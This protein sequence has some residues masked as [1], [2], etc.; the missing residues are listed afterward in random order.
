MNAIMLGVMLLPLFVVVRWGVRYWR[1]QVLPG[2]VVLEELEPDRR[3][4][5]GGL[6]R[7]KAL[8]PERRREIARKAAQ[9]RWSKD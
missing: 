1:R 3:G 2:Y 8:S 9:A 5:H 7:A 6:A 4:V